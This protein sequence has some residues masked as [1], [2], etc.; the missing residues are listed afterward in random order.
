MSAVMS[1]LGVKRTID[2]HVFAFRD[3]WQGNL[4]PFCRIRI[5][6]TGPETLPGE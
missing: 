1:A 6:I 2:G 5:T 3:S 4:E